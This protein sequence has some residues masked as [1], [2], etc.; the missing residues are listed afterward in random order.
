MPPKPIS[1]SEFRHAVE[2]LLCRTTTSITTSRHVLPQTL[3][4]AIS[5]GVDSIAMAFLFSRLLRSEEGIRTA[6]GTVRRAVGIVV[7][8]QLRPGSALEALSVARELRRLGLGAVVK[9]MRWSRAADVSNVESLARTMRYRLLG[10]T[11]RSLLAMNLFFAHHRDDEYETVLMRLIAG[12]GYRG[13]GGIPNCN[14]IPECCHLYGVY[15]SGLKDEWTSRQAEQP[16]TFLGLETRPEQVPLPDFEPLECEDG[17]VKIHRPLLDFDK[18]RL[19]ATCEANGLRWFED[20]TNSDPTLTMR[21]AVRYLIRAHRLP[22]ALQKPAIL[23]LSERAKLRRRTEESEA[24]RLLVREAVVKHFDPNAGT[25]TVE[26]PSLRPARWNPFRRRRLF[27]RERSRARRRHQRVVAAAAI[28]KLIDFATPETHLPP[29]SALEGTVD[30]LFPS[31]GRRR[32][33]TFTMSGVLFRPN[34]GP[35]P[36]WNLSRAPY[37]SSRPVPQATFPGSEASRRG[38]CWTATKLW[39]GRFWL[40]ISSCVPTRLIVK[41]LKPQHVKPFRQTLTP[42]QR[43]R[44]QLLLKHH[45]TG[46]TRYSLPALYSEEAETRTTRLLALPS[47]GIQVPGLNRWIRY[48]VRALP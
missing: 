9:R 14:D 1:P 8:H 34:V 44:L 20:D 5:G 47:L 31:A 3:A 33:E 37:P 32:S 46:K 39:D 45:A 11:C 41:P 30:R 25:L 10:T 4:L 42:E 15:K 19:V 28:R 29:L 17:G 21:N 38:K 16:R 22:R 6:D 23:A 48:G 24:H 26:L 40:R 35:E 12:H 7:D 43:A 18:D 27:A 13:L 2:A 36:R